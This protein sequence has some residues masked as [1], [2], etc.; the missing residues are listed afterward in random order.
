VDCRVGAF[1]V[2]EDTLPEADALEGYSH[3]RM[4]DQLYGHEDTEAQI[5]AAW[6]SGRLH[7]AIMLTGPKGIGKAT[8][9]WRATRFLLDPVDDAE[10]LD[11]DR[12]SGVNRRI[13][14]LSEP[15]LLLARRGWDEKS[16]KLRTQIT[17][18]D[19]RDFKGFFNFAA[20][21]GGYRVAI[22]DAA[23]EMNTAA[24][25]AVLKI[26]EEP[27]SKTVMFLV[28]HQPSRLLPTI[29]S[30]CLTLPMTPLGPEAM[31]AA[32]RQQGVMI[33]P[34]VEGL[35][36]MAGGSVGQA[37]RLIEVGGPE[38]YT[39]LLGVFSA[40]T[41]DR[42]QALAIANACT[43]PNNVL[44]Y[45]LTVELISLFLSRLAKQGAHPQGAIQ[46]LVQG[47]ARALNTL[48]GNPHRARKWADLALT[49]P[50]KAAHARA[51]NLDPSS[52][53]LDMLLEVEKAARQ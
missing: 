19:M 53:I 14:A 27:P 39:A 49:L 44:R 38:L 45:E 5:L 22:I 20:T 18:D 41:A 25:N 51:V 30:R 24:A 17:V 50:A 40:P 10:T 33:E 29:R 15:R 13:S 6:Q 1:G 11:T 34:G 42:P 43:G 46:E 8:F 28:A 36:E 52:V 4:T 16:K 48:S 32:L 9:A 21:D 37:L 3:P 35:A 23:D 47:E 26:L 12:E 2:I 7:H 31:E